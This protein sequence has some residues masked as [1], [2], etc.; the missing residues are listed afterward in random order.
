ML[1]E[2]DMKIKVPE[3]LKK[4]EYLKLP[5]GE[6]E[7]YVREILRQVVRMNP[8]GVTVSMLKEE[9]PFNSRTLEKHLSV[10]TFTNEIYTV[11]IGPNLL[12]LPNHRALHH[13]AREVLDLG[14]REYIIYAVSNR[15]GEFILIQEKKSI[16]KNKME[17]GGGIMIPKE[18]LKKLVD[19]LI[20]WR[21]KYDR[22]SA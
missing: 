8:F 21:D 9:L 18:H 17:I 5:S 15:L 3:I 22:D 1:G 14:N 7:R 16:Q 13:E 20:E 2:I 12:Y 6:K 10:L 11:K 19:F 4:E